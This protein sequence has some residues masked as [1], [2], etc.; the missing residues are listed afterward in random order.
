MADPDPLPR[1][2]I[3][4][5]AALSREIVVMTKIAARLLATVYEVPSA[6]ARVIPH[7]VPRVAWQEG[8]KCKAR[9]ELTNR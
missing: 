7:G 4:N 8:S 3:Q 5:V 9:L 2:I 1:R 6:G